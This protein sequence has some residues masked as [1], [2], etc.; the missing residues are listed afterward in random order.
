MPVAMPSLKISL[1]RIIIGSALTLGAC[2]HPGEASFAATLRWAPPADALSLDPHAQNEVMSNSLNAHIYERLVT[3]DAQLALVPGLARSWT[4]VNALTWRFQLRPNV[5][6]HDGSPLTGEDVVFSIQRAQHPASAVAQYAR[7]LGRAVHLG[8]G[9]IEFRLNKPNP[10]FLDHADAVQIMSLPWARAHGVMVPLSLKAKQE[11]HAKHNAMGTGPYTVISREPDTQTVLKRFPGYWTRVPGNVETLV[12][13]PIANA[14]TRTAAL[15]SGEVDL[16]TAPAA[17]D[18]QRLGTT[19]GLV[20]RQTPE[21]RVVF[22]GFDQARDELLYSDV[23]GKNP[24][25]DRRV[26]QALAQ[27]I[28]IQSIQKIILRDQGVPTGCLL[29]SA[30]TCART[31]ELD[32]SQPGFDLTAARRL[33]DE[34][35]YPKGF[36]FTLDCP[37][38]R[39]VNDE[40]L[41]VALAGMLSRVGITMRVQTMPRSQFF[42]KLDRLD[43]SAY[44]MAWGGAELD[45]QPTMDP[46]MH[47][48]NEATGQGDVN[49]GRFADAELDAL[50]DASAVETAPAVRQRQ[51]RAAL[52]R[53]QTQLYHLTLYRQKLAWAMRKGVEAQPV[54]NNHMRAWLVK[55]AP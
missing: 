28:D 52:M 14:F 21:N 19:A 16:V 22:L 6:F 33:L 29:P 51:I 49:F 32:A 42:P 11:N 41:C 43:S 2:L 38:D 20:V 10:V 1:H 17:T 12:V 18:L 47:S 9:L 44:L 36:S 37:N 5:R 53:H 50:I 55:L 4:Q 7:G 39:N 27:A 25:K 35:G 40:A 23:K 45:P 31:P 34:A 8:K 54:A 24:F 26:R 13:K 15:V 46:I 30:L 48:F 3:R